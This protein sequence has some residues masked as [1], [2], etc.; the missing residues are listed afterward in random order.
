MANGGTG[1]LPSKI[2]KKDLGCEKYEI[3]SKAASEIRNECESMSAF[4]AVLINLRT[5][6]REPFSTF[7]AANCNR[8][9]ELLNSQPSKPLTPRTLHELEQLKN[10]HRENEMLIF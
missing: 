3:D 6:S 9:H 10:E 5:Q 4:K 1:M 7:K 2:S 8:K